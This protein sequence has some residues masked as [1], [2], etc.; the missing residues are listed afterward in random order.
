MYISPECTYLKNIYIH[1]CIPVKGQMDIPYGCQVYLTLFLSVRVLYNSI[2]VHCP[3]ARAFCLVERLQS[4]STV[5]YTV[6]YTIQ[7]SCSVL[8]N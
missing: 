7:I 2:T 8:L 5:V 4:A 3:R 1:K 6:I